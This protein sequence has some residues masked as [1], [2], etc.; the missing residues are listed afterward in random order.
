MVGKAIGGIITFAGGLALYQ[1]DGK[2]LGGLGLSG[3]TCRVGHIIA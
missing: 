3:A 1:N 2:I